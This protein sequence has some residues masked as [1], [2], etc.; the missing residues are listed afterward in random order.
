MFRKI[1]ARKPRAI[2]ISS[3]ADLLL[4]LNNQKD[5][6]SAF[7]AVLVGLDREYREDFP[8]MA[9]TLKDGRY[10]LIV[11][12]Q[13]DEMAAKP[14]YLEQIGVILCH[15]LVHIVQLHVPQSLK[16][17]RDLVDE[18]G[19]EDGMELWRKI[20]PLAVDYADNS[21][22]IETGLFTI[23]Q[24]NHSAPLR[25]DGF[26]EY[27]GVL[28]SD[29][30]LQFGLSYQEYFH[31]LRDIM[32]KDKAPEDW[33]GM[34]GSN[35]GSKD[36]DQAKDLI[37][38]MA[39]GG[40]PYQHIEDILG[41]E[42]E[43]MDLDQLEDLIST[44]TNASDEIKRE[45]VRNMKGRGHGGSGL[46]QMIEKSLEGPKM[47]WREILAGIIQEAREASEDPIS[48]NIKPSMAMLD[49]CKK[50]PYRISPFP[51]RKKKPVF[52]VG[53]FIDTSASVNDQMLAVF[54]TEIDGILEAGTMLLMIHCDYNISH[55]E[56][57][58][59]G[60]AV[61]GEVHGRGGTSF[62]PP[63]EYVRDEGIDLDLVL[64]FTDGEAPLPREENRIDV[65]VLWVVT[66]GC[67]APGGS[68]YVK[69]QATGSLVDLEYGHLLVI[70]A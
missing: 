55:I 66:P 8:T 2:T 12:N 35:G 18:L 70:D 43:N 65:P 3:I 33:P 47:N 42:I 56:E 51:G 7:T 19:E 36:I 34:P 46:V 52:K 60:G 48:T 57:I 41:E 54:L 28:P 68:Y 22:C 53:V 15:E 21:V 69:Y 27:K 30:G 17:L 67:V 39:G 23:D 50:S 10:R 16:N 45:V 62:D 25:E 58:E 63:F 49:L 5:L 38:R 11:G 13:M 61:K 14:E 6:R 4:V 64:Y 1:S 37:D 44:A 40:N 24:F 20:N 31:I 9:V 29:M 59:V 32:E 26:G